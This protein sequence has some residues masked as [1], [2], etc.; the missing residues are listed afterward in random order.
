[1]AAMMLDMR[2]AIEAMDSLVVG[3]TGDNGGFGRFEVADHTIYDEVMDN[4]K[5]SYA[6]KLDIFHEAVMD[7]EIRLTCQIDYLKICFGVKP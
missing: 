1:M 2:D 7:V 3:L 5:L 6:E 4:P